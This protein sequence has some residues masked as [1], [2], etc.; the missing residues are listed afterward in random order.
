MEILQFVGAILVNAGTGIAWYLKYKFD[1]RREKKAEPLEA[2]KSMAEMSAISAETVKD[3][4]STIAG[5]AKDLSEITLKF[6]T[7]IT[8]LQKKDKLLQ[9]KEKQLKELEVELDQFKEKFH[10]L[11]NRLNRL[12]NGS[13][14]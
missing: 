14:S 3:L 13:R 12:K 9:E 6:H 10:E 2:V 1:K 7:A 11:Q 8:E 4:Q 5:M